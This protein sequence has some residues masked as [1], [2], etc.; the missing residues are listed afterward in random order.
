[1]ANANVPVE[2]HA[3]RRLLKPRS[4]AVIG[5]SST[6]GALGASVIDNLDRAKFPGQIHLINPNRDAIGDRPCLKSA[7]D[8][9]PGVDVALLAIPK[10]AVVE[11]IRSLAAAKVGAAII[12]S[13]GFAEDGPAGAREQIEIARLAADSGMVIEG[14]NCL[15]LVNYVDRIPLTFIHTSNPALGDRPGIGVVSQSGAMA[16]VLST[17]LRSRE[18]G[19]SYSV[20]TGNE[21]Q[22]GVEDYVQFLLD[23]PHTHAI[24]M[25]VEHFRQPRRFLKLAQLARENG[26]LIVVLHPGRSAAARA[27]AATHTGALAGDYQVMRTLVEHYGVIVAENLEE[28]GDLLEIAVRC[29][30][31]PSGG[32]LVIAE[33]GAYKALALD[34]CEQLKLDLPHLDNNNAPALRAAMPPFV[35]VTNPIDLTAQA[36]ADRDMYRRVLEAAAGDERFGA[37]VLDIIQ[38]DPATCHLKFPVILSAI[39]KLQRESPRHAP[40]FV[41]GVDEGAAIPAEYVSQ[42]RLQRTPFFPSPD[43]ALRAV[44]RFTN[45]AAR[46]PEPSEPAPAPLPLN[47]PTGAVAEH[48]VKSLLKPLGIPFPP[49]RL[50]ATLDDALNAAAEIGFPVALKVQAAE[51]SHKSDAGGVAL[52]VKTNDELVAKWSQLHDNVRSHRPGLTLDGILVEKMASPGVELIIGARHDPE[53]GPILLVGLGGVQA[54]LFRDIRLLPPDLDANGVIAELHRLKSAP[55]LHGFRGAPAADVA[56]VANLVVRLGQ[57]MLAE[58]SIRE[59]DLNPVIVYPAGQGVLAVDAI[60]SVGYSE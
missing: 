60:M 32:A 11:T 35:P 33:S 7:A 51:L 17:M 25:I 5:A 8:L 57:L 16:A 52:N 15:G 21:A 41:A 13:A 24:G 53:W 31:P 39:E 45:Q 44:A 36:L 42:L 22:T 27:S 29:P 12:F 28:L 2:D 14:P 19:I 38:T 47:L 23:D 50:A 9:P 58:P 59:I 10:V 1:M 55:L 40:I 30:R 18:L 20:S 48:R 34:L 54:E 46:R 26:K 43:R 4:V 6:P 56:A 37:I 3:L 49:G